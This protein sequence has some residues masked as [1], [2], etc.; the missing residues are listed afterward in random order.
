MDKLRRYKTAINIAASN[1]KHV[2]ERI[3]AGIIEK[4]RTGKINP[5][6]ILPSTRELAKSLKVS[7]SSVMQAIKRLESLGWL[8]VT[9]SKGIFINAKDQWPDTSQ[10]IPSGEIPLPPKFHFN[11]FESSL[12]S[13]KNAPATQINFDDGFADIKLSPKSFITTYR[14]LYEQHLRQ[15]KIDAFYSDSQQQLRIEL[16]KMLQHNRDLSIDDKHICFTRGNQLSFYLAALT[17]LKRDDNIIV[18]HPGNLFAWEIFQKIGVRMI[19]VPVDKEGINTDALECICRQDKITLVYVTPQCQYPTT[20]IMSERRRVKLIQLAHAYDFTIM[21]SDYEHE[22]WFNSQPV[23]PLT[24]RNIEDRVI[25]VGSLSRMLNPLMRLGFV[26]GPAAYIASLKA[27]SMSLDSCGDFVLEKTIATLMTEGTLSL[28][29]RKSSI[30]YRERRLMMA[31]LIEKHLGHLSDF[32]LPPGGLA[33][34]IPLHVSFRHDSFLNKLSS[35]GVSVPPMQLYHF[36]GAP[37][38]HALRLG[39]GSVPSKDMETGIRLIAKA[40]TL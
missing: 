3:A 7:R 26:A 1:E 9:P 37:A 30:I 16:N 4:I 27:L 35:L 34:W 8:K 17:L 24:S 21:E 39:F 32:Q 10:E 40:L 19:P 15:K 11:Y 2:Y 29:I 6:D 18:E 12:T 36:P 25:Y 5:G 28:C 38:V 13:L 33:F 31:H 20:V 22:F 14:G 23:M